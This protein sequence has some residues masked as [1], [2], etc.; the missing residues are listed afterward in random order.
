M[1]RRDFFEKSGCGICGMILTY[2]GLTSCGREEEAPAEMTAAKQEPAAEAPEA[3]MTQREKIKQLL[4]DKQGKTEEEAEAMLTEF[5]EK[6]G[7]AVEKCICED[8][9]TYVAEE[10][11]TVFCNPVVGKSDVITEEKGCNCPQC[12]VYQENNLKFGYYCTRGS[13][14][15]QSMG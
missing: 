10:T 14:L 6:L 4:M 12:P 2:F 3:A 11:E 9:P 1:K 8:C 7:P 15:E 13:E 5:E